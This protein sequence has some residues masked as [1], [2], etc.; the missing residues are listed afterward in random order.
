M[1]LGWLA[2]VGL[3]GC[4]DQEE[5][6]TPVVATLQTSPG[7]AKFIPKSNGIPGEY[8]V[9]FN[10][11]RA[12]RDLDDVAARHGALVGRRYSHGFSARMSE[13]DARVL[14]EDPSVAIVEQDS[15]MHATT[16]ESNATQGLD[17]IDQRNLP[18]DGNY[19]FTADGTGVT[20]FVI[21]TGLRSTHVE[22]TGRVNLAAG[23]TAIDDGRGTEDCNGHGTHVSGTIAGT[24]L[25]VA[26]KATV[27]PIR[28]LDCEGSGPT[29]GIIAGIDFVA[30]NH[31]AKS[32][33]NM[34]LGGGAS[35]ALDASIRS[36]V[37]SG[38]TV[39]VAAGNENQNACNVSPAREPMAI[40]VGATSVADQRAN[41]SNF[42][43]CVDLFAPGVDITSAWIDTDQTINTISG[44]SMASPHVAG[45]AALI[46]SAN[47][48]A[49]PAQVAATLL[50]NSTPGKVTDPQGSPNRLLFT[51]TTAAPP[52][53]PPGG[54]KITSPMNG[55][56]V[57]AMFAVTV[58]AANATSVALA[59]DGQPLVTDD[60]APFAFTVTNAPAGM[61]TVQVTATF[62]GGTTSTDMI[63]VTVGGSGG[64]GQG[65]PPP[66]P[67]TKKDDG[68]GCSTSGGQGLALG[69]LVMFVAL[70]RKTRR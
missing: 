17:R 67:P 64:L 7:A 27:V 55:A 8:I 6:E 68:G 33:A 29:S 62:A 45:V 37:A 31:P 51:A 59:V 26:K 36:L 18:L 54:S 47:P 16:V 23:G 42:G 2:L 70:R 11:A 56:T 50:A 48:T 14:A 3:L 52:P 69:L 5:I 10:K 21:D 66:P 40:T 43:T 32:V 46:L 39:V 13:A 12:A 24:I 44:T 58:D 20:V 57:Q 19:N 38:V 22:F 35:D 60:A 41:F 9:L 53:P 65:D 61:H 25:G 28:V 49:T 30:Q 63:T 4:V 1:K 15:I 34:S